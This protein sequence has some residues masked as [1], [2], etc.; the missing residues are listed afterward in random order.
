MLH[1]FVQGL[2]G[3]D[4]AF[5]DHN[6]LIVKEILKKDKNRLLANNKYNNL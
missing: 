6:Q 3:L 4:D 1:S 2:Q 5:K